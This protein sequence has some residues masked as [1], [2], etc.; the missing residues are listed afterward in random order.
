MFCDDDSSELVSESTAAGASD[1]PQVDTQCRSVRFAGGAKDKCVLSYVHQRRTY[2]L[3][4]E[5][6][7]ATLSSN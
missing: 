7:A 5:D 3:Q 2:W 6:I 4:Y 1:A